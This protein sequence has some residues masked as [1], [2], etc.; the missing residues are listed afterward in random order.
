M[1]L[2][3]RPLGWLFS[4]AILSILSGA[5]DENQLNRFY[6]RFTFIFFFFNRLRMLIKKRMNN[7]TICMMKWESLPCIIRSHDI[8]RRRPHAHLLEQFWTLCLLIECDGSQHRLM[9]IER[10]R[11]RAA[12]CVGCSM[13]AFTAVAPNKSFHSQTHSC[14]LVVVKTVCV[15]QA[16]VSENLTNYLITPSK[17]ILLF[18]ACLFAVCSYLNRQCNK[19]FGFRWII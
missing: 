5:F 7:K 16:H 2:M 12:K 15:W 13:N 9:Q 8:K 19:M 6:Y 14:F 17:F 4:Y 18:V 10:E 1:W 11:E 3:A